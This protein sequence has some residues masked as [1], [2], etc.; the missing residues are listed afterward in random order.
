[1]AGALKTPVS[2]NQ[3]SRQGNE[4]YTAVKNVL[5]LDFVLRTNKT[6]KKP[7]GMR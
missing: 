2:T 5:D 7:L 4:H 1:L 3:K 6:S